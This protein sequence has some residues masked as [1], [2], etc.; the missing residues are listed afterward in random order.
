MAALAR[1]AGAFTPAAPLIATVTPAPL[2]ALALSLSLAGA[3]SEV[4]KGLWYIR[5]GGGCR[6]LRQANLR[7]AR[8]HDGELAAHLLA[9]QRAKAG[10]KP[11]S[12]GSDKYR[13]KFHTKHS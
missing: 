5:P 9:L 13:S 6:G 2:L 1:R 10:I 7:L 3:A 11:H 4:M 8:A 12:Y